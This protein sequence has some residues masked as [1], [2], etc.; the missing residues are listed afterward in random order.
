MKDRRKE[1]EKEIS[2]V[3]HHQSQCS[4]ILFPTPNTPFHDVFQESKSV[5]TAHAEMSMSSSTIAISFSV[6]FGSLK[7]VGSARIFCL[8]D[9][10]TF[11]RISR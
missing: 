6:Y 7:I 11:L 2:A 1:K 5:V 3:S 4:Q 10:V 9:E 8:S